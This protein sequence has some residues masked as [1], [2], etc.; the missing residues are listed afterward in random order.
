MASLNNMST[1]GIKLQQDN[2]TIDKRKNNRGDQ[3]LALQE[4]N[5][6][7]VENNLY[8]IDFCLWLISDECRNFILNKEEP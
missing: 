1:T 8:H 4:F 5:R 2:P 7:C 3:F 6:V